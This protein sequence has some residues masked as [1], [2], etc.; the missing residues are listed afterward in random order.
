M[1][2]VS[3]DLYDYGKC[4]VCNSV[5]KAKEYCCDEIVKSNSQLIAEK[6]NEEKG[7]YTKA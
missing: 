7:N 2:F 5:R 4:Q 1:S 6:I 3:R